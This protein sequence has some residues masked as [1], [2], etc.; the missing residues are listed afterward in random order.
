MGLLLQDVAWESTNRQR[1]IILCDKVIPHHREN[2]NSVIILLCYNVHT[3][4]Y[5]HMMSLNFLICV[6]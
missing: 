3:D 1:N 4:G 5:M 2:V 6:K